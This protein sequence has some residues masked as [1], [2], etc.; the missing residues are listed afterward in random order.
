MQNEELLHKIED[1]EKKISFSKKQE[2]TD[3]SEINSKLQRFQ[4]F[5]ENARERI[6]TLDSSISSLFDNDLEKTQEI[7]SLGNR[8]YA[9]ENDTSLTISEEQ[10]AQIETNSQEIQNQSTSI[11]DLQ[12]AV[13]T[14]SSSINSLSTNDT[15]QQEDITNL[16]LNYS[17]LNNDVDS[18]SEDISS[19]SQNYYIHEGKIQIAEQNIDDLESRVTVLEQSTSGGSEYDL[20]ET[21]NYFNKVTFE[22]NQQTYGTNEN[23]FTCFFLT[24]PTSLCKIKFHANVSKISDIEYTKTLNVYL[25]G[26]VIHS[27]QYS[28]TGTT[29]DVIEFE[30]YFYPQTANNNINLKSTEKN[31]VR[32]KS[33]L[34]LID[35]KIEIFGRNVTILNRDTSFIVFPCENRYY[36]TKNVYENALGKIMDI[37]DTSWNENFFN[38]PRIVYNVDDANATSPDKSIYTTLNHTILPIFSYSS[39]N[40]RYTIDSTKY[41]IT[42]VFSNMQCIYQLTSDLAPTNYASIDTAGFSPLYAISTPGENDESTIHVCST[43]PASDFMLCMNKASNKN[44]NTV[45]VTLN[46]EALNKKWVW[47]TPVMF[48]DWVTNTNHP[49]LCIGLDEFG[50]NIFFNGQQATYTIDLGIGSQ[51][52]A[53]GQSNGSI[54]VYMTIANKIFKKVLTINSSTQKYELTSS[55]FFCNGNEYIEG[56][57][58]DY[59]IKKGE[60]WNYVPPSNSTQN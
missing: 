23:F 13:S 53:F 27:K 16:S 33:R 37:G 50:H 55:Q 34:K 21:F 26:E 54:N 45:A 14:H 52:T 18:M 59:F 32:K 6:T 56:I 17:H 19:L 36:L 5:E 29:D 46:N 12:D 40:S 31:N 44:L 8:I 11:S 47:C 57:S 43:R 1:I 15:N 7:M 22:Q 39:S 49:Y 58:D 2:Q 38:V 42:S 25:N 51:T 41:L 24:E 3:L 9:L 28:G 60:T 10:L 30:H 20:P 48:N 4:A 35:C